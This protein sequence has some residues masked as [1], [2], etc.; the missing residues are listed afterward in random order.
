MDPSLIPPTPAQ[1]R[2]RGV[3]QGR[4]R[5]GQRL[6]VGV[7]VLGVME[8]H[9]VRLPSQVLRGLLDSG[10]Q[11]GGGEGVFPWEVPDLGG[12]REVRQEIAGLRL[13]CLV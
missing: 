9:R 7:G 2:L 10:A 11:A 3:G 12:D 1:P 6:C 4:A 5:L 13:Q 8:E